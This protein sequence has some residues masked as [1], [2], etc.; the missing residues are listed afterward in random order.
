LGL[1]YEYGGGVKQGYPKALGCYEDLVDNNT[2]AGFHQLGLMY[3]YGKG[4]LVDYKKA[5]NLFEEA[6]SA[7]SKHVFKLP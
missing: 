6:A 7:L 3:Y 2:V 4:V 1:L 5:L